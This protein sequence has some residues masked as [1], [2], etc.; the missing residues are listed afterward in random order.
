MLARAKI[1]LGGVWNLGS[2][3]RHDAEPEKAMALGLMTK[4]HATIS[5]AGHG[6]WL[7]V[8]ID[9]EPKSDG[10]RP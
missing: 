8:E 1:S 5:L 7:F 3:W 10:V 2:S 4:G 9:A 6:A